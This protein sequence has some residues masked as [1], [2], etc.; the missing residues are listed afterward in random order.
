[1][2]P[3]KL[4]DESVYEVAFVQS[5]LKYKKG[6]RAKDGK[7]FTRYQRNN[8]VFSVPDDHPFN[9]DFKSGNVKSITL[10]PG[11]STID[12]VDDDGNVTATEIDTLNFSTYINKMQWS[13]LRDEKLED[14]RVNSQIKRYET[15]A[16]APAS[17]EL[18][19]S[20]MNA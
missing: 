16:V 4:Q 14:A 20:L 1:M 12:R 5:G 13:S 9:T 3:I 6:Q 11:T 7:T 18:I 15:L 8:V 2:E 19:N 10:I 17:D